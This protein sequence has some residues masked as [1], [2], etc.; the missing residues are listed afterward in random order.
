MKDLVTTYDRLTAVHISVG[1][2]EYE[3]YDETETT[4]V[5]LE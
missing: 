4:H 5:S 1:T 3:Y 2:S